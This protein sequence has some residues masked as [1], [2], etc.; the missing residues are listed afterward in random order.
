M[1]RAALILVLGLLAAGC[2]GSSSS[3]ENGPIVLSGIT[4]NEE[5]GLFLRETDGTLRRLTG[6]SDTSRRPRVLT[7]RQARRVRPAQE[8]PSR[9]HRPADVMDADGGN[10]TQVGD[11]V[12][13]ALR[14]AWSPDDGRIRSSDAVSGRSGPTGRA[15][16]RIF[17]LT[18]A[19]RPGPPTGESWSREPAHGLTTMNDDGTDMQGDPRPARPAEGAQL[20]EAPYTF[21]P[22][23]LVSG[24]R[25][26]SS[27]YRET[28]DGDGPHPRAIVIPNPRWRPST[29][30]ETTGRSVTKVFDSGTSLS[31]SP[32]GELIAYIDRA[33][34]TT[35]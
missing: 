33:C 10:A 3:G 12:A 15:P 16:R 4:P 19:R 17:G 11:V 21:E 29:P 8:G 24:R 18:L 35:S 14:I 13:G 27:S 25:S 6:A 9:R 30:T 28:S 7:R 23:G 32:D 26:G 5:S 34:T 22:R 20:H 1:R 31:W 2:G